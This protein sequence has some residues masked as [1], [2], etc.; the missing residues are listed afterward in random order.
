MRSSELGG[1]IPVGPMLST[2]RSQ[3]SKSEMKLALG[4]LQFV[5]S[6]GTANRA[7]QVTCQEAREMLQLVA[8][9]SI[10]TRLRHC[11]WQK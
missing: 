10:Y 2:W 9:Y 1:H 4:T 3:V 11:L 5:L 6:Y 7:G 8:A